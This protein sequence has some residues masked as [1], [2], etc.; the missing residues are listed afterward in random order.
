MLV[1]MSKGTP[2]IESLAMM[3]YVARDVMLYTM[4]AVVSAAWRAKLLVAYAS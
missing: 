4:L 2:T 1:G 3:G